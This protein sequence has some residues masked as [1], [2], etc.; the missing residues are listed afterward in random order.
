MNENQIYPE[1][2][3]ACKLTNLHRMSKGMV[4]YQQGQTAQGFYFIKQGLVGLFHTLDNGKE[5]LARVDKQGDYFGFRT[6]FGLGDSQ[7]H[8]CAKVLIEADIIQIRPDNLD[9]FWDQN[10]VF[11]KMLMQ[12]LANELKD[13]EERLAKSAYLNTL[14][15]IADSLHFLTTNFPHYNWTYRE[16]AEYAGC[17]TETAIR[18]SKKLK[19]NHLFNDVLPR[20]RKKE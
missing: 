12:T 5:C 9:K 8:C 14:D 18:M 19:Q 16:I 4:V 20:Q 13:A 11:N 3:N 6:L 10:V 7:Y 2:L 1:S 15:R 17:E